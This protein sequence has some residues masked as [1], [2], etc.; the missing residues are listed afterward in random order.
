VPAIVVNRTELLA[1]QLGISLWL[2]KSM[3]LLRPVLRQIAPPSDLGVSSPRRACGWFQQTAA[4]CVFLLVTVPA[5][6]Q[7]TQTGN[8]ELHL[9]SIHGTLTTTQEDAS[10]GLA[11]ITVKLTS[12]P[13]DGSP[14]TADTDDGGHYE[15]KN[16]KPGTYTISISQS[17][18]K[19][20][21]KSLSLNAGEAA[22]VDIRVELQ[23]VTEK[24]EV[25][26]QTQS[27]A[28][29]DVTTPSVALTQRQLISLPTAQ[30]K[31]R[32][33]LPV[34]PGVVKTQ[35]GKLNFKGADE[36]Q[37]LLIVNSAR[38]TDPVTGSFAVPV[39]TDAVQSFAV[40]KTPYNAGLGSFSGGLT[41]VETKPPDDGWS[42][43]LKSFIPSVLGKN[44]SMVGLQE[45]TPGLDFSAPL[46][47]HKLLFSEIFQYDMKK[48]TVRGLPW[49][50]DISKK[51]GFSTF[52]TLEV[53]LSKTHLV[54]LTVNAYPLRVQ[55]ADI[56]ALVPQPASNDLDQKGV[57]VGLADRYQFSSGAIFSTIAQYTRFD[58]NAH[59]QGPADMLITP[60]G[61]GGNFFNQ[62]SR[63][64][65]E[66]QVVSAYQFAEK[67][68]LGRHELHVGVDFDHR[69]YVGV[70]S[71]NPVQILRQ[72]GTLAE[73]ITFL[74]GTVQSAADS[75]V[76]EFI[77]DHWVLDSHWALNLGARLSTE[78]NGWSA[79]VAPR[80]GV[81]YSPG[82][83]GKTVIRAGAG[84]FYSLLPLLAGNFTANPTQV[85]T[86][87]DTAGLPSGLPVTYTN[88]YVGGLNPLTANSLASQ[89]ETTPRNLTWNVEV[90]HELRKNLLLRVG[91]IDSHTTYLFAVNPF[92][93]AAGGQSFLALTNTG[94]SHY[95]ELESTVHFTFHGTDEINV[96]Y[97][98][99]R[100]RGDLNNLSAVLIPFEQPVIRPNV[101]G[102]LPYDVPNRVVTWG[103]I[104]LPKS[105]KFSPIADLHSGYPYSNIDTLQN[106]VGTPNGQR[107][108]SFF[109]L[110]VKIYR[111]FRI[112]F[113]GSE[114]GK[115]KGHHVRLGFYSLNVTNHGNFNA[116]YNNV[117]APN[118]GQ[119]AGFL[120]R[121]EGAVIDFVD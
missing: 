37:S 103:I 85:V 46:I 48:R 14:L 88:A 42:Y 28:T 65:K 35:D 100:T 78:T 47:K 7:T 56:N 107:F 39:P 92:T 104:S 114:H 69:S 96:S 91:Y 79:A 106:Y 70:S 31:I 19:P 62:W 119:F 94:S 32:E 1:R 101:Y 102:I 95:R 10:S 36:N 54:M 82:K 30:E 90:E 55:H 25:S 108:A 51:Q 26:E 9:G 21:T 57:T 81:A 15:F 80:A 83:E 53:I 6:G 27:I 72:D 22:V 73:E 41:E 77:Q 121:R 43:R 52:S 89:P 105:F 17:G 59:G 3:S 115:G 34:T 117:T 71:S 50:F 16:L 11:G 8:E 112:P 74:P 38:T 24:V 2:D 84:L 18:F 87:F 61:W 116:V 76:A 44:G 113:L 60:E 66:F 12:V 45:A 4:A 33:V 67:H 40:Y 97:V 99:S 93:A 5:L 13:P 23:S 58:S 63:R 109:T 111:Q 75:A 20:F 49:P 98:W 68:W 110:D 118:F 120:D 29:E 64:G 86:P